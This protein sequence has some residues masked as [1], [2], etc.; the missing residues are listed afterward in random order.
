[1]SNSSLP[2]RCK[3][4]RKAVTSLRCSRCSV[5]I[6][7]DCSTVAPVGMLCSG[8]GNMRNAPAFQLDAGSTALAAAASLAVA[9]LGGWLLVT[10]QFGIFNLLLAFLLGLAVAETAMRVTGRKRGP[11]VEAVVGTCTA[12]GIIIGHMGAGGALSFDLW[13]MAMVVIGAVSAVNRIKYV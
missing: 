7:P 11:R 6:C 5:P 8:C 4:R 1:M 10:V 12:L 9:A 13:F 2:L 3:C